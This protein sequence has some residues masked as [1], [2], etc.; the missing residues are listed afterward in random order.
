MWAWVLTTMCLFAFVLGVKLGGASKP[1]TRQRVDLNAKSLMVLAVVGLLG[2]YGMVFGG[3]ESGFIE[4]IFSLYLVAFGALGYHSVRDRSLRRPLYT[5]VALAS[6]A[7]ILISFKEAAVI[8]IAALMVG[9]AAAG[10]EVSKKKLFGLIA[11]G[12][13]VF[14]TVQGNRIAYDLG[15][16]VPI[17]RAAVDE[18]TEYNIES[19]LRG[20][21][22]RPPVEAATDIVQGLSRRFGGVT[23]IIVIH[24]KV[25]SEKPYLNGLSIW[26]PVVSS[27]PI[28]PN[29]I[30]LEFPQL[31]LGRYFTVEFIADNPDE[32]LSS[33]AITMPGDLYLNFG[34]WGAVLGLGLWGVAMGKLDRTFPPSSAT[35]VGVIVYLSHILIGVE[36]NIAF[37]TVN[38][39]IRVTLVL[40][41]LRAAARWG[42]RQS[43]AR[44]VIVAG[45]DDPMTPQ[46]VSG[47]TG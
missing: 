30:N 8:P 13:W 5:M 31:S 12:I 41:L 33:Q 14:L 26:Q 29:F 38:A 18:V 37:L 6:V 24:E 11:L 28:A 36:R 9:M 39:A 4:S 43:G 17:Y 32:N 23:G 19:G 16:D 40:L 25:P 47:S 42:E 15:D 3:I 44:A 2:R 34:F 46:L 10:V 35:K 22:G 20:R 45:A 1:P 7:G 21:P 27:I